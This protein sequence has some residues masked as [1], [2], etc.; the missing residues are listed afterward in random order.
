MEKPSNPLKFLRNFLGELE[1]KA[2]ASQRDEEEEEDEP[3]P[4]PKGVGG[5]RRGG[6]SADV[7][8]HDDAMTYEKKVPF[9]FDCSLT[10]LKKLQFS[11]VGDSKGCRDDDFSSTMRCWQCFVRALG[12]R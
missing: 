1:A 6:V 4:A 10:F 5:S 11:T 2:H 3:A 12:A 9:C 7:I 8:E